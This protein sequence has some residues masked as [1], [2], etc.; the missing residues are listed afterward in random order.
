MFLSKFSRLSILACVSVIVCASCSGSQSPT[1]IS[2]LPSDP[3]EI[4][5]SEPA[6]LSGETTL[7][8][9]NCPHILL[10]QVKY[11]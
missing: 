2:N 1:S 5:V 6:G 8:L 9:M 4:S 10:L 3:E 11:G 7:S